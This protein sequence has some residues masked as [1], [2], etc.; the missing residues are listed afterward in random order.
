MR[1]T[2]LRDYPGRYA[3]AGPGR[4]P[5]ATIAGKPGAPDP[6]WRSVL[7]AALLAYALAGLF[8]YALRDSPWTGLLL[9]NVTLCL[10]LVFL[11]PSGARWLV[12]AYPVIISISSQLFVIPFT[13]L[14]DGPAYDSVVRQYFDTL[15]GVFD[16]NSWVFQD[17]LLTSFKNS[18]PGI[19]P[20]FYLPER[21]FLLPS[22]ADYYLWQSTIHIGLVGLIAIIIR[23]WNALSR[24]H[25]VPM[26]LFSAMGP[27]FFD[28][29]AAPTRHE[30]TF[31]GIF[32]FFISYVSVQRSLT[33]A[34]VISLI[35]AV[36]IILIS[37]APLML[38]V[39]LFVIL[40]LVVINPKLSKFRFLYI[41]A[42]LVFGFAYLGR[43][44]L[45][46]T[47][48]YLTGIASDTSGSMGYLTRVPVIGLVA[49]FIFAILAPFPWAKANYF[50]ETYYGGNWLLFLAHVGSS[51]FGVY[52]FIIIAL[53]WRAILSHPDTELR[54]ILCYGVVMS[55]SVLAGATAFHT[56]ILI[57]FPFFAALLS[58]PKLAVHPMTP[59]LAV[60][61][62]ELAMA[63]AGA[64]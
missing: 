1:D 49:K 15:T 47:G 13:E 21:L 55:S 31:F 41:G 51:L 29:G 2:M 12:L 39:L 3:L 36:L 30:F 25:F 24:R 48:S 56:Y 6:A 64:I 5:S 10:L 8:I 42:A 57:Y 23:V 45:S 50:I 35:S 37:K 28:L 58:Y 62:L 59:L 14:G 9:A 38:P 11:I 16:W 17:D 52:F 61:A 18:S 27:S 4:P 22:P 43:F 19:L 20:F 34:K 63:L 46:Q 33:P 40:D 54:Q 53:R 7:G 26:I 60:G 44:L 32:L